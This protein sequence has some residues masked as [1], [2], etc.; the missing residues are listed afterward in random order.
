MPAEQTAGAGGFRC[1][2][3]STTL[4]SSAQR[5][6]AGHS[7]VISVTAGVDRS[8]RYGALR[9][10]D[11]VCWLPAY[12]HR[13]ARRHTGVVAGAD[14]DDRVHRRCI[15]AS[16]RDDGLTTVNWLARDVYRGQESATPVSLP[17]QIGQP[18]V[19][20]GMELPYCARW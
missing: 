2:R 12:R 20:R 3:M 4:N 19:R 6:L 8:V 10:D 14:G 7:P 11:V 9:V 5:S 17:A 16:Q 1:L 18:A 13:R 15:A